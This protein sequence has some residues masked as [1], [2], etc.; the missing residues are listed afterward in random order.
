V[1]IISEEPQ[2]KAVI[3]KGNPTNYNTAVYIILFKQSFQL[4]M[5]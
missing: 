5:E 1:P 4:K 2:E 3:P